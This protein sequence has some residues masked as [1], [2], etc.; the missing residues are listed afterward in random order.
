[1]S[2][3]QY[4]LEGSGP[5]LCRSHGQQAQHDSLSLSVASHRLP[6]LDPQSMD[7]T[8]LASLALGTGAATIELPLPHT[9]LPLPPRTC[10]S[11]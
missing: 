3:T 10:A 2:R 9:P 5:F 7:L 4:M 8:M 11:L 6:M 1:M